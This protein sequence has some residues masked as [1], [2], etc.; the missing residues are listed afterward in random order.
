MLHHPLVVVIANCLAQEAKKECLL[1]VRFVYSKFFTFRSVS[2]DTSVCI[3]LQPSSFEDFGSTGQYDEFFVIENEGRPITDTSVRRSSDSS[4]IE[5]LPREDCYR[6]MKIDLKSKDLSKKERPKSSAELYLVRSLLNNFR[7]RASTSTV[8]SLDSEITGYC[9]FPIDDDIFHPPLS[10]RTSFIGEPDA[11][12]RP[13]SEGSVVSTTD[14]TENK[15]S[16]S[17]PITAGYAEAKSRLQR[18]TSLPISALDPASASNDYGGLKHASSVHLKS[19]RPTSITVTGTSDIEERRRS[20]YVAGEDLTPDVAPGNSS[21]PVSTS[22]FMAPCVLP[23]CSQKN[24]QVSEVWSELGTGGGILEIP[25]CGVN[26]H[27]MPSTRQGHLLRKVASKSKETLPN[28]ALAVKSNDSNQQMDRRIV[29]SLEDPPASLNNHRHV[30]V[31]SMVRVDYGNSELLSSGAVLQIDVNAVLKTDKEFS[32]D[33]TSTFGCLISSSIVGPFHEVEGDCYHFGN[34]LQVSISKNDIAKVSTF[35]RDEGSLCLIPIAKLSKNSSE[36]CS[37]VWEGISCMLVWTA[38]YGPKRSHANNACCVSLSTA[39]TCPP[40]LSIKKNDK[41]CLLHL[42]AAY[43]VWIQTPQDIQVILQCEPESCASVFPTSTLISA[44]EIRTLSRINKS[45]TLRYQKESKTPVTPEVKTQEITEIPDKQ[46]KERNKEKLT[47][48]LI[49]VQSA[50]TI[51]QAKFVAPVRSPSWSTAVKR[52]K[53]SKSSSPRQFSNRPE[54][55]GPQDYLYLWHDVQ[56]NSVS[57][58]GPQFV[59]PGADRQ[60]KISQLAVAVTSRV[61]RKKQKT[62]MPLLIEF[63]Q[64]DI[65]PLLARTTIWCQ[66]TTRYKEW[67][68]GHSRG[69]V[70]LIHTHCV[71]IFD[72]DQCYNKGNAKL[73]V[74]QLIESLVEPVGELP[75]C[76]DTI[77]MKLLEKVQDW[78]LFSRILGFAENYVFRV[79][80]EISDDLKKDTD[81]KISLFLEKYMEFCQSGH[82]KRHFHQNVIRALL[83]MEEYELVLNLVTDFCIL[84]VASDIK[85]RWMELQVMYD[86][87]LKNSTDMPRKKAARKYK[88]DPGVPEQEDKQ[89]SALSW[90]I[91]AR[92]RWCNNDRSFL[93]IL[94]QAAGQLPDTSAGEWN[95]FTAA[96]V[97]ILSIHSLLR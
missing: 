92:K 30:A 4:V 16:D 24:L 89:I 76:F 14:A 90:L 22:G 58:L 28:A 93:I 2:E 21:T 18:P 42:W 94:H 44:E 84:S 88:H 77:R 12:S 70:G 49:D 78:L 36:Y 17:L 8:S 68:I 32:S 79:V 5:H 27:V 55:T 85:D 61:R 73:S 64:S 74:G 1:F 91:T 95:D 83:Y 72:T 33:P 80:Q 97:L 29:L 40:T 56:R 60:I 23:A 35:S 3:S 63:E 37:S 51:V 20:Y 43:R 34:T 48:A 54:S 81:D 47:L 46:V 59:I 82:R 50:G 31:A 67:Y 65:M 71:R 87:L 39:T 19:D 7:K 41:R 66:G 38:V 15:D 86:N 62:A 9:A 53:M 45:I 6:E 69:C 75:F 25:G 96:L 57:K 13:S 11:I 10:N 52:W 26:F